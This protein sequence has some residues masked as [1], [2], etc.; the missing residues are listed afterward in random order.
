MAVVPRQA[1]T[2]AAK[3]ALSANPEAC[4]MH[5]A[6]Q[7]S[8]LGKMKLTAARTALESMMPPSIPLNLVPLVNADHQ[9]VAV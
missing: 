9:A 2:L 3:A 4:N 1:R 7:V 8:R 5:A 6:E